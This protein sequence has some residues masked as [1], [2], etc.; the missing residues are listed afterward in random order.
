MGG[1]KSNFLIFA[2]SKANKG[3]SK[4]NNYESRKRGIFCP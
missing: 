1:G 2:A 4:Q 3:N